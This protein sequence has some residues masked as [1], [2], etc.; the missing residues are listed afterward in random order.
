MSQQC[1]QVAKKANGI[2]AWIRYGVASR[3]RAVI[4]PLCSALVRLH[5]EC[6]V[7]FWAPHY[8]KD[9]E[10]LEHV[11][12]RAAW[13]VRALK[14]RSCEERLRELGLFS[15]EK[16]RLRGDLTALYSSL[17]GGCSEVGVGLFS[18]VI[19]NRTRG[20]DLTLHQGRFRLEIR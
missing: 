8:K 17:K 15:L 16:R 3:S 5:L 1:A 14:S 11:Q 9:T 2:L 6:C 13:L 7:W 18:Q 4:V 20:N 19:S 12:G 10:L